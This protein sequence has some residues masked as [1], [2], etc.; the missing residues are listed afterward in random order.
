MR[1]TIALNKQMLAGT[2]DVG[3]FKYDYLL[4]RQILEQG[5]PVGHHNKNATMNN[6]HLRA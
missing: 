4:M 5:A 6:Q 3:T 2:E 1:Q